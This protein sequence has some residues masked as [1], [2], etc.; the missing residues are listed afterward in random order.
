LNADSV[1]RDA[2]LY[3]TSLARDRLPLLSWTRQSGVS[4]RLHEPGIVHDLDPRSRENLQND[5]L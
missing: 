5:T 3:G 2:T 4:R 1:A